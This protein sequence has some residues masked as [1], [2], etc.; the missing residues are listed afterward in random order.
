MVS[1]GTCSKCDAWN[2]IKLTAACVFSW[3]AMAGLVWSTLRD[4]SKVRHTEVIKSGVTAIQ[5]LSMLTK[6]P[7][8]WNLSVLTMLQT[9]SSFSSTPKEA[10]SL[11]CS[12]T[13]S[14]HSK[15][16]LSAL[17]FSA[18]PIVA[19]LPG[20]ILFWAI[21]YVLRSK[22]GDQAQEWKQARSKFNTTV[23]VIFFMLL[24]QL[25]LTSWG[26]IPCTK[27][28]GRQR[29]AVDLDIPCLGDEH[30][31]WIAL[32]A[33]P[34]IILY[35]ICFLSLQHFYS[36][37]CRG[38][39]NCTM[40]P[41]ARVAGCTPSSTEAFARRTTTGSSLSCIASSFLEQSW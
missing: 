30:I 20:I 40:S 9:V 4:Q 18:Y 8:D 5:S 27:I 31:A 37:G 6:Y 33:V 32:L 16:M 21:V 3:A 23:M 38:E 39:E 24:P 15:A 22:Q 29:V 2:S 13:G 17:A 7:L 26:I 14:D 41:E 1:G 36:V 28:S 34:S 12:I 10:V 25:N 35:S 11:D 19:L